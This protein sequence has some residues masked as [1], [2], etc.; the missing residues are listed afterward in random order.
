MTTLL[1]RFALLLGEESSLP[2]ESL[3]PNP[4][5]RGTSRTPTRNTA[6]TVVPQRALRRSAGLLPIVT[7][8]P[9]AWRKVWVRQT[10]GDAPTWVFP[11]AVYDADGLSIEGAVAAAR[12]LT[13]LKVALLSTSALL[14]GYKGDATMATFYLGAADIEPDEKR[15]RKCSLTAEVRCVTWGEALRLFRASNNQRDQDV[16]AA[17]IER[18]ELAAHKPDL[19]IPEAP[20]DRGE[21]VV[22]P[23]PATPTPPNTPSVSTS[24]P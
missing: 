3:L 2:P 21:P 10:S 4:F 12:D 8:G 23:E 9:D 20:V 16:I 19:T 1:E 15:W 5:V 13:G 24:A 17:A 7:T 14:G 6:V 18:P 11:E 22:T